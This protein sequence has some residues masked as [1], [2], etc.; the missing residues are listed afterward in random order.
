M[1][2]NPDTQFHDQLKSKFVE[3]FTKETNLNF[4]HPFETFL[5]LGG[6]SI[7]PIVYYLNSLTDE[8]NTLIEQCLTFRIT[9]ISVYVALTKKKRKVKFRNP[10]WD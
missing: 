1:N 9:L 7:W 4:I 5:Y 6:L 10:Y 8:A 3:V 2:K